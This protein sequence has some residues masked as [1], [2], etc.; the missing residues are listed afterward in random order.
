MAAT[1]DEEMESLL[2]A[3]D[4]IYEDAKSSISEM[5]LLQSHYNAELKM[6]ESLQV[7]SNALKSEKDRLAKLYSE[8]LKNLA[9]Q[10]Y[11]KDTGLLK[12]EYEQQISCLEAQVKESLH[13]KA[14]Y[15]A[16]ISQLHGDLAAHKSHMQV[17][18]MRLDQL[19]VEVESKYNSEIQ[20]LKECLAVEQEEKNELNRKIQ[21]LEK[22]LLICKAKLVDQQQEMTA[23][24]QV[25]TL[26][27]KIMKLRKENEV[28]KRKLS[29]S[30]EGK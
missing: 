15:E 4:Q 19:N 29:H 28:L 17:I 25:E 14:T 23:N 16:T 9:D 22:E 18:A 6:R 1:S 24:W 27:Q 10:G 8:S 30:E 21:N 3:F 7:A 11:R 2:S 12:R 5:Q 20:D 26:K 13:E